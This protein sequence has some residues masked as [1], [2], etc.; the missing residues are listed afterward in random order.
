MRNDMDKQI[1]DFSNCTR[2][3]N[4]ELWCYD[5]VNKL[6]YKVIPVEPATVPYKVKFDLFR[7]K[8]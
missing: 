2:D 7:N 4:G 3:E 5:N 1:P 6:V 8:K